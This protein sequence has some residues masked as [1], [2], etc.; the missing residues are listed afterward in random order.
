[1]P[2]GKLIIKKYPNRRLYD[3]ES[4]RYVTLKD[5]SSLI[6]SG[7][8]VVALDAKTDENVTAFILT[9]IIMESAKR[10][11]SLLPESLLH[12]L[13]R[14]G[15]DL[16]SEFFD[17]YLEKTLQSYLMYKKGL[18][19]QF[20]ICLEMGMDLSTIAERML[21]RRAPFP[22]P[23]AGPARPEPEPNERPSGE[24]A[25]GKAPSAAPAS[26]KASKY[27]AGKKTG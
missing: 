18:E 4:S 19:E 17:N 20:R 5:V 25:S 3:T 27:P 11:N 1:M 26:A 7:R 21:S 16:L 14:F 2:S 13:I 9:Q 8:Q 10:R 12:L 24:A 23:P 22:M 6:R 15:D